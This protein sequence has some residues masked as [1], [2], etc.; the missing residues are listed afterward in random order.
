MDEG[1]KV[2]SMYSKEGSKQ[3][4]EPRTGPTCE[5]PRMMSMTSNN[6]GLV[7]ACTKVWWPTF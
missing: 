6:G 1:G 4:R 7:V 2:V 5:G 3:S